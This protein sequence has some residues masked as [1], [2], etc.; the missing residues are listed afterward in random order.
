MARAKKSK[1]AGRRD[2]SRTEIA[3]LWKLALT[4]TAGAIAKN[5]GR[6]EAAV[7]GKAFLEGISFRAIKRKAKGKKAAKKK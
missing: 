5:I 7:R 2:W 6:S 4:Q 3:A 1:S